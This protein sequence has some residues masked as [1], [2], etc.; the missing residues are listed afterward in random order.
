L[1]H[2][3]IDDEELDRIVLAR[4][5]ELSSIPAKIASVVVP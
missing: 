3:D 2:G 5:E 4:S 1:D